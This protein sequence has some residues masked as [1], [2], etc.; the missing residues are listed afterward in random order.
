[1]RILA[2]VLV[3]GATPIFAQE[4]DCSTAENQQDMNAC[5]EAEWQKADVFLNE[6]YG[7]AMAV[8]KEYDVGLPDEEQGAAK[9]MRAAQRA[10]IT[11]RDATC[12]AEGFAMHGGSAE[13]LLVY[14]CL[15]RVTAERA[16]DLKQIATNN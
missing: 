15:A 8:M 4:V 9:Q 3:L 11:Y 2:L 10:W 14:G 7:N 13:P 5:A 12:A 6:T 1:M 16:D